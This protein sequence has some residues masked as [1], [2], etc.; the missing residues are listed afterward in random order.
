MLYIVSTSVL[1]VGD[2]HN[3]LRIEHDLIQLAVGRFVFFII[4]NFFAELFTLWK[5]HFGSDERVIKR[6]FWPR[7]YLVY[8]RATNT[9]QMYPKY[10]GPKWWEQAKER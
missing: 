7:I 3:A 2:S 5:F 1:R 6:V 10:D 4:F 9:I 8:Q